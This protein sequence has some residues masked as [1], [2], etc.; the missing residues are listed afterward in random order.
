MQ[1]RTLGAT[2]CLSPFKKPSCRS[3]AEVEDLLKGG[4]DAICVSDVLA[5]G[6][7]F[8]ASNGVSVPE[9]VSVM[10]IHDMPGSN[11]IVPLT[12]IK[13][14]SQE[15]GAKAPKPLPIGWN[16]IKGRPRFLFRRNWL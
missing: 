3:Q 5:Y 11:V 13:L 6:V 14:P 4:A 15:M 8:G 2:A 16:A 12:T 7:I 9:D 10:G 1:A